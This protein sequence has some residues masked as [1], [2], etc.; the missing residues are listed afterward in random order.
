MTPDQIERIRSTADVILYSG[1]F[2]D[3][4]YAALFEIATET[5]RLFHSDHTA[6]KLKFMDM[7]ASIVGAVQRPEMFTSIL[8]HLGRQHGR[9]GVKASYYGPVGAALLISLDAILGERMTPQVREAWKSLYTEIEG[10]MLQGSA[11]D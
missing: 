10:A 7:L 2:A 4:Y 9:F 11:L 6:L 3:C 8:T 1:R 5:R